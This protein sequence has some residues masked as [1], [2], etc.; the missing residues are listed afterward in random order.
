[1]R[2]RY[3]SLFGTV[4]AGV[5]AIHAP[6]AAGGVAAGLQAASAMLASATTGAIIGSAAGGAAKY[7]CQ[8]RRVEQFQHFFAFLPRR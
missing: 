5:R 4:V 2:N 3:H 8:G 1:M 6:L 7:Y